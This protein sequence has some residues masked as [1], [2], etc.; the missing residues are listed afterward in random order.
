MAD[1]AILKRGAMKVV[2]LVVVLVAGSYFLWPD[3]PPREWLEE[4]GELLLK[5]TFIAWAVVSL[6]MA[7]DALAALW[8]GM[9]ATPEK[10]R[11]R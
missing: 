1:A 4:P 2:W 7:Y 10:T 9:V 11:R 8:K 3:H 5:F 6:G